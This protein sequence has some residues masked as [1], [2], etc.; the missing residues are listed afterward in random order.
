MGERRQ[1]TIA[2]LEENLAACKQRIDSVLDV[3]GDPETVVDE[4]GWLPRDRRQLSLWRS[5]WRREKEVRT[6]RTVLAE[7]RSALAET[8]EKAERA[9]IR[10]GVREDQ[11]ALDAWL[12]I[13][14]LTPDDMCSEC[15][16]PVANHLRSITRTSGPCPAWPRH[17][18]HLRKWRAMFD[19]MVRASQPPPPPPPPKPEPLA[20]V[21]SGLPIA[22]VMKRLGK[23]RQAVPGRG[24]PNVAEPTGGRLGRPHSLIPNGA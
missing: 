8:K 1:A 22:E 18:A 19:E 15:V 3:V 16:M 7:K 20:V 14:P 9:E 17:A 13:P 11:S 12:A 21:P 5:S 4:R 10:R 24:D 23:I 6:L 2:E